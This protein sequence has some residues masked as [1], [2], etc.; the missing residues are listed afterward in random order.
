MKLLLRKNCTALAVMLLLLSSCSLNQMIKLAEEQKLTVKPN[1]LELHGDSVKFDIS[2]NLP[3]EMLKKGTK[4]TMKTSY[5]YGDQKL[6]LKDID[7]D[8]DEYQDQT[9]GAKINESFSLAYDDAM[10]SGKLKIMGVASK[11]GSDKFKS[12]PELEIAEGII[13]TSRMVKDVY[14]VTYADPG[15]SN[16]EELE[17]LPTIDFFFDK[18][19]S[20]LKTSEIKGE[21]GESLDQFIA[22]KI[23]TRN[24]NI[25]GSHSPEGLE[26]INEE[27]SKERA[28]V[29]EDFYRERMERYD[30]K[31][32]ADS[33]SFSTKPLFQDW[34]MLTDALK[35]ESHLTHEQEEQVISVTKRTDLSFQEKE[36][37]LQKFPFYKELYEHIYPTLRTS[38][39]QILTVKKKKTVAEITLISKD[40]IEGRAE[41]SALLEEEILYAA[42]LTPILTE[43]EALYKAATKLNNSWK[44]HTN[45]SSTYIELAN[46]AITEEQKE[47]YVGLAEV[48]ADL[49]TKSVEST[50]ATLQNNLGIIALL[51]G[52][53]GKAATEF[54]KGKSVASGEVLAAIKSSLASTQIASANYPDAV[55]NLKG[56]SDSTAGKGTEFNAALVNT[57]KGNYTAAE[58]IIKGYIEVNSKDAEAYYLLSIIN[59]RVDNKIE[60]AKNL[61]KTISLDAKYKE[62]LT[63]DLEFK[64]Y[65]EVID[66]LK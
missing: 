23:V 51:K 18:N 66:A 5:Q 55:L 7:I 14:N 53:K 10:K 28:K 20:I 1:P 22:S 8:S 45:L 39:T 21:N 62:I 15:Y 32:M 12:T 3:V 19:K 6:E 25:I 48:Q 59:A 38:K 49:A 61:S 52:D 31:N 65:T 42:T 41:P 13:T 46:S 27:L 60:L 17:A 9:E 44:S 57:L 34:K 40:I 29:I 37:E 47:T 33:I 4:Y 64:N 11:K 58:P 16:E 56:L 35:Y 26:A 63:N 36:L 54:E 24:V 43:K 50:N 30:Y 2:A